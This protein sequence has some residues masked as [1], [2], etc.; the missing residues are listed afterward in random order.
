MHTTDTTSR[1][2]KPLKQL[3]CFYCEKTFPASCVVQHRKHMCKNHSEKHLKEKKHFCSVCYHTFEGEEE[4]DLHLESSHAQLKC[5]ECNHYF[6]TRAHH[7]VHMRIHTKER[8][9]K[10][11]LCGQDFQTKGHLTVS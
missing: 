11:S 2:S 7:E 1:S 9:Y 8:P 4:R 3:E 10:C 5:Q 6:Q